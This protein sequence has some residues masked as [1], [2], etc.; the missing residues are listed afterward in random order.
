M[1]EIPTAVEPD[2]VVEIQLDG[3]P[4]DDL[5]E[6]LE[7]MLV[8]REFEDSL[9]PLTMSGNSEVDRATIRLERAADRQSS[10]RRMLKSRHA[11]V[12]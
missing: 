5:E 2:E 6:W 9:E 1:S 3:V 12:T 11:A 7:T 8:I 10:R 4:V